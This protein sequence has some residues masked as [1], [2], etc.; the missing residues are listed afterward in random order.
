MK[1][2]LAI[3]LV[4]ALLFT[5]LTGCGKSAEEAEPQEANTTPTPTASVAAEQRE[6]NEQSRESAEETADFSPTDAAEAAEEASAEKWEQEIDFT[7]MSDSALLPYIEDTLYSKLVSDLN[8]EEYFVEDVTAIYI[9]QEYINELAYNSQS[10]IFFG[11]TISELDSYFQG[12]RYIFTLGEDGNT[13][14]KPLETVE[15]TTYEQVLKNVAIGTG[16]I[17]V[18]VTVSVLTAGAADA[19]AISTIFAV[20]AKT[21]AACALSGAAFGGVSAAVIRGYQTGDWKE[22]FRAGAVGASEGY[23]WGAISG[24]L[25]GGA[26]TAWGL[27]Q[28][29]GNGLTMNEVA[30][31]QRESG[32][33]LQ[34]I[35]QFHTV[36]EYNVFKNAGLTPQM[37]NGQLALV[38][39]IDISLV[40]EYGRTNLQRMQQGLAPLDATGKS[41]ELHHIGQKNNGTIAILTAKEHDSLALHGFIT[42]SEIDRPEFA[43]IR[44]AFWKAYAA[45]CM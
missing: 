7:G 29:T 28:A 38:Q 3:V 5:S 16:V 32:Y 45:H 43:K 42:A 4:I 6:A 40:D 39:N 20:S 11:Y 37:V 34:V 10:N 9:S 12:T 41:F 15:D 17:L 36:D 25:E 31:I 18:C 19:A 2:L 35:K 30:R 21:G 33:P 1:R 8:S 23:K 24:A 13:I 26:K 22:A 44:R 14:V 27:Y